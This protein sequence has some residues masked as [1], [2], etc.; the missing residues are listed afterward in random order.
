MR[1]SLNTGTNSKKLPL[2]RLLRANGV[3]V[4]RDRWR[5]GVFNAVG[6]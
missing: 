4:I 6:Y 3:P 5:G 2:G 1:I